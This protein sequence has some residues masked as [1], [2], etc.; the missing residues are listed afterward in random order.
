MTVSAG[1][2]DLFG[3]IRRTVRLTQ[4]STATVVFLEFF[5]QPLKVSKRVGNVE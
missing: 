2:A 5:T 1:V 4:S 3:R